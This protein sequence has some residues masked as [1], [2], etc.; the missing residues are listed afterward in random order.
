M[1]LK[2]CTAKRKCSVNISY[3]YWGT[4]SALLETLHFHMS[5]VHAQILLFFLQGDE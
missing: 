1:V 4:L 2:K 3:Y 5:L